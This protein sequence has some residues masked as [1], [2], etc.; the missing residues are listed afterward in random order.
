MARA[1]IDLSGVYELYIDE[2]SQT[3]H[4]YLVLGGVVVRAS[5]TGA[6]TKALESARLPELP[7]GEMGWTKVSRTKL[8]AY[9]RFVDVFFDNPG[10]LNG[11]HF[12]SLVVDTHKLN[13]K[14][15]NAGSRELGF[16]KEICLLCDKFARL[17]SAPLFYVY[18]DR[19][20]TSY[21]TN[22]LRLIIN[23][24]RVK[25]G[26]KRDWPFR[27]VH[28]RDG[29]DSQALQLVDILLGGIAFDLNGHGKAANASPA[30]VALSAHILKRARIEN[31]HKGTGISG[32]F[33]IWHREL[34]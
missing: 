3:N 9:R 8:D 21:S 2:S 11:F 10:G 31:T 17:Y 24:Y 1:P 7:K 23:R 12:H 27:R 25:K 29:I 4:R 28:F 26:D 19:R 13:D 16:N 22:D 18:L 20:Q 15:F 6:L 33:T 14:K 5:Q 30:K 32:D 34:G